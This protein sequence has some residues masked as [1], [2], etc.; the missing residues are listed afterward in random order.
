MLSKDRR[1]RIDTKGNYPDLDTY[2]DVLVGHKTVSPSV[3]VDPH[4]GN[5]AL[6]FV[7]NAIGIR[8]SGEFRIACHIV[9]VDE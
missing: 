5:P 4:T 2:L 9:S 1:Q 6:F 8:I 3:Y 7:V